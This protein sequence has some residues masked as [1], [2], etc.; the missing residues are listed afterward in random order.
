MPVFDGMNVIDTSHIVC[1]APLLFST[2]GTLSYAI[3]CAV[4]WV[5]SEI[6]SCGDHHLLCHMIF[7]ML[8]YHT[9]LYLMLLQ[10]APFART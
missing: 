10:D 2:F 1:S 6:D 5:Y 3:R 7:D 8:H 4:V 9:P